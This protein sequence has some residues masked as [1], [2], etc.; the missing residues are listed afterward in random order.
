MCYGHLSGRLGEELF[1]LF[2]H[3]GWIVKRSEGKDYD[4]SPEGW[5]QLKTFNIDEGM[6]YG[7]KRKILSPCIER[8]GGIFYEHMGA[9]L[10]SLL[11]ERILELAWV[12]KVGEKQYIISEAGLRG[13]ESIGININKI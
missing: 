2:E 11:A 3:K 5:K 13:F 6:L 12:E 1:K 7:S 9:H 10:G 8:H 4:I